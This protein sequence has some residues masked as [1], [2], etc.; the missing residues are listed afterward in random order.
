[1]AMEYFKLK[2]GADFVH[3]PYRGL[4]PATTDLIAN[5][6]QLLFSSPA[7]FEGHVKSGR[8]KALGLSGSARLKDLPHA[9]LLSEVGY[10]M[11]ELDNSAI[12]GLVTSSRAPGHAVRAM[13]EVVNEAVRDPQFA[14][15]VEKIGLRPA[16]STADE[17]RNIIAEEIQRWA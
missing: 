6:V 14:A 1:L 17:F 7:G 11:P 4:A 13:A 5:H 16:G 2:T 3:V 8:L 10:A 12:F 9:P 15:D